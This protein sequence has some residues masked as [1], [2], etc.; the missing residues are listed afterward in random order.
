[1]IRYTLWPHCQS[2]NKCTTN[3]TSCNNYS[4]AYFNDFSLVNTNEKGNTLRTTIFPHWES[5]L[6]WVRRPRHYFG[7]V[8]NFSIFC[9]TP[10]IRHF[11]F[12][13]KKTTPILSPD[14]CYGTALAANTPPSPS[15]SALYVFPPL[16]FFLSEESSLFYPHWVMVKL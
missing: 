11:F 4:L 10:L 15:R 1:M 7:Q 2:L 6:L 12:P 16:F 14:H 9:V 5:S 13:K 3:K 8:T